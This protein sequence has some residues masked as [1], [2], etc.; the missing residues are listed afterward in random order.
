MVLGRPTSSCAGSEA[1]EEE[2][3]E[4][5]SLSHFRCYSASTQSGKELHSVLHVSS[6]RSRAWLAEQ[7]RNCELSSDLLLLVLSHA[8]SRWC[9]RRRVVEGALFSS[10]RLVRLIE[11]VLGQRR[12][13]LRARQRPVSLAP[14]S[15]ERARARS[16]AKRRREDCF[17]E[18]TS[19]KVDQRAFLDQ[20]AQYFQLETNELLLVLLFAAATCRQS[21]QR[22]V[23]AAA[24]CPLQLITSID[25]YE[26]TAEPVWRA[27]ERQSPSRPPSHRSVGPQYRP[28]P[29]R[30]GPIRKR[31]S[32]N[33]D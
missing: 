1:E 28:V 9:F 30:D 5:H 3:A 7:R 15:D 27:L 6:G 10:T 18:Q 2:E 14:L 4:A 23:E 11:S 8:E 22:I 12:A 26:G 31:M 33:V 16:L 25:S 13:E 24:E 20:E 21:R 19:R 32:R 17:V 29:R